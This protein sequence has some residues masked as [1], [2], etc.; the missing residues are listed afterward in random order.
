MKESRPHPSELSEIV[1]GMLGPIRTG[2]P[3]FLRPAVPI[4]PTGLP[5]QGKITPA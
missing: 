1:P 2:R 3:L 4:E 5:D